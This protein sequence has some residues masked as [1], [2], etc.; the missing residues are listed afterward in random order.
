MKSAEFSSGGDAL[1]VNSVPI[2]ESEDGRTDITFGL[3]DGSTVLLG[4]GNDTTSLVWPTDLGAEEFFD[5]IK[6]LGEIYDGTWEHVEF[7]HPDNEDFASITATTS[8]V[9]YRL[10]WFRETLLDEAGHKEASIDIRLMPQDFDL[11]APMLATGTDTVLANI[12][13]LGVKLSEAIDVDF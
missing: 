10:S 8:Q 5:R 1:T 9:K 6:T 12:E 3:P 2:Y 4:L 7:E 11:T 13:E